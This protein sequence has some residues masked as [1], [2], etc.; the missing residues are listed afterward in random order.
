M[1]IL[2]KIIYESALRFSILNKSKEYYGKMIMISSKL[3]EN[4]LKIGFKY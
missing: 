1:K 3:L 4:T 2:Q